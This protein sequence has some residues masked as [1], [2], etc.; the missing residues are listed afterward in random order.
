[1]FNFAT[2]SSES[3][4]SGDMNGFFDSLIPCAEYSQG[5]PPGFGFRWLNKICICR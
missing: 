3:F 5:A 4:L 1:M 2:F